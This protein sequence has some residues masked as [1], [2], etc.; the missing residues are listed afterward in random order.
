MQKKELKSHQYNLYFLTWTSFHS[1]PIWR[2]FYYE[3]NV[4]TVYFTR[5]LWFMKLAIYAELNTTLWRTFPL[6][7][8]SLCKFNSTNEQKFHGQLHAHFSIAK[9]LYGQEG[10]NSDW[11]RYAADSLMWSLGHYNALKGHSSTGHLTTALQQGQSKSKA[12][13][14]RRLLRSSVATHCR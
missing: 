1:L 7:I 13:R 8:P 9:C 4:L 2:L 5:G 12:L 10:A 3:E 11:S 14:H 6:H